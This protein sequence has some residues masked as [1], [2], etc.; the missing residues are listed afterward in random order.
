MPYTAANAPAHVK[1]LPPTR[2]RQWLHIF[3]GCAADG[4]PEEKCFK[5][6]NGVAASKD[7]DPS[8]MT[9]E[10]AELLFE[11]KEYDNGDYDDPPPGLVQLTKD[12]AGYRTIR[13][14]NAGSCATC[15]WYVGEGSCALVEGPVDPEGVSSL[16]RAKA[17]TDSSSGTV[18][19][20]AERDFAEP[21]PL[22][23][24]EPPLPNSPTGKPGLLEG[25]RSLVTRFNNSG[26]AHTPVS[27]TDEHDGGSAAFGLVRQKDG[28]LRFYTVWSNNFMDREGEIFT[29]AAHKEFVDWASEHSQYPELWLWHTMGS[30]FGQVDWLD[31]TEDGFVHASG[32]IDAGKEALAEKA[33]RE[34]AGVSHGFFGLQRENLIE[35]YRSYEISVLP[36]TNAAVWTTSFNLLNAGKANEMGFTPDKRKYFVDMGIPEDQIK[37]WETATEGLAEAL[38]TQGLESKAA[39]LGIEVEPPPTPEQVQE[40][41]FRIETTKTLMSIQELVSTLAAQVKSIDERTKD[42]KSGDAVV[43]EAMTPKVGAPVSASKSDDN[44]VA[45][46]GAEAGIAKDFFEGTILGPLIGTRG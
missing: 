41:N 32:L 20:V 6:A 2:Q 36:V 16:W 15:H 3:N 1:K 19:V 35:W 45:S 43:A 38:K 5:M 23:V 44:V 28:R 10:D 42:I 24:I 8:T 22:P 40:N 11:A 14:S 13:A 4:H 29:K 34:D 27:G 39:D 26:S 17:T 21:D 37:Q 7:A 12:V 31:L 33:A 18:A 9:L 25:L 30:K 46:T